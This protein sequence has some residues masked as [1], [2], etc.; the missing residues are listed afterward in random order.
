MAAVLDVCLHLCSFLL[1]QALINDLLD[2][3]LNR[4]TIEAPEKEGTR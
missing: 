2:L 1:L 4:V 3:K